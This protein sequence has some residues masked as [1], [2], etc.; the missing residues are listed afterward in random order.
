VPTVDLVATAIN[1]ASKENKARQPNSDAEFDPE[2]FLIVLDLFDK[3]GDSTKQL[4]FNNFMLFLKYHNE[5][6]MKQFKTSNEAGSST[7]NKLM[8]FLYKI[9]WQCYQ[10]EDDKLIKMAHNVCVEICAH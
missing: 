10:S 7:R 2:Y 3:Y 1:N 6:F 8:L 4:F 5:S 9:S